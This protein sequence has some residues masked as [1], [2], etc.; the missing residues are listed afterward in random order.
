VLLAGSAMNSSRVA[1]S[2]LWSA[3]ENGGLALVSFTSLVI[4]SRFLSATDFGLFSIVLAVVELA[5]V[6]VSMLFHDALVQ[7]EEL[8]PLHFD[9]AFTFGLLLSVA[10]VLGS[11]LGAPLFAH[12]VSSESAAK[13]LGWTSLAL[14]CTAVTATLVAHQRREL[15]FRPLALRSLVGR[16]TGA[17]IGIALVCLGVGFWALVAQH[18]LVAFTGSLALW[19]SAAG[20]PRLRLGASELRQLL[21][22]GAYSVGGLFLSF[23]VKRVFI[24]LVGVTLGGEAAGYLNLGFRA[25]DVLWAIAASAVMQVALPVLSRLQADPERRRRAYRSAMELSCLLLYPC[26]LG[27][28]VV[29]PELVELLFG[30]RWMTAIPYVSAL[31]VMIVVQVPGL[32]VTAMLSA[33]GRPRDTL[34]G[35]VL[36]LALMIGLMLS[37]GSR[38]LVWA[39]GIWMVREILVAPVM[40]LVLERATGIRA[41]EQLRGAAV[42]L[43]ASV[44]MAAAVFAFRQALPSDLNAASRL[45]VLAPFGAVVFLGCAWLTDRTTLTKGFDFA[46]SAVRSRLPRQAHVR[47]PGD[48]P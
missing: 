42:P 37:V 31:A 1:Q 17:A 27:I 34:I 18:V 23:A 5:S 26:F 3:V 28:A 13:A 16:L 22:F 14:P 47:G 35:V 15:A 39:M 10:L 46:S 38:S 21:G 9:S 33:V 20:H 7:K 11:W 4:Y 19:V 12:L 8:T 36:Q 40:V 45:C 32:L 44:T 30:P 2:A 48:I 6:L 24:I 29:A 41:I 25:V 43:V